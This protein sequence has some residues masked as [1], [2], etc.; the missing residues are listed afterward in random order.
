MNDYKEWKCSKTKISTTLSHNIW[1]KDKN[2]K[3]ILKFKCKESNN[4]RL[5]DYSK[6]DAFL[7]FRNDHLTVHKEIKLNHGGRNCIMRRAGLDIIQIMHLVEESNLI[8]EEPNWWECF[9]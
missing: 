1:N 9:R 7:I 4:L 5:I 2:R 3:K 6:V 8:I